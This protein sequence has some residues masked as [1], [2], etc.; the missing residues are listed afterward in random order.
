MVFFFLVSGNHN[1]G[2]GHIKRCLTLAKEAKKYDIPCHF[3]TTKNSEEANKM[4]RDEGFNLFKLKQSPSAQ[5]I[6]DVIKKETGKRV[7][8]VID[9]DEQLYR[10]V[11]FQNKIQYENIRL[12]HIT[13]DANGCFLSDY[14]LNQNIISNSLQYRTAE[15]TKRMF[16]LN[17]FIFDEKVR[18]IQP[19]KSLVIKDKYTLLIAFGGADPL[20]L[21]LK[22]LTCLEAIQHRLHKIFVIVG[23][24]NNN[25][26]QI[27]NFVQEIDVDTEIIYN[28]DEMFNYMGKSDIALCSMGLTFWELAL[29]NMPSLVISGSTREEMVVDFIAKAN[30]CKKLGHG[31][32]FDEK[33]ISDK[34]TE[35]FNDNTFL[36]IDLEEL[37]GNLNREGAK[38]VIETILENET[39]N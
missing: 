2:L 34:L 5:E 30:Y 7:V 9:S 15:N 20:N 6:I 33:I 26:S 14:L 4:V 31:N 39:S 29:H 37:L 17:Y 12:M 13:V 36:Q 22:I 35:T 11:D 23:P 21:T 18:N 32:Q 19:K 27:S 25:L 10:E 38:L 1:I 24:L 3:L 28:T 8:L 16:G